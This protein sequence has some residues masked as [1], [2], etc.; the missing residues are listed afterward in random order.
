MAQRRMF[1]IK[2]I[3]S[4]KFLKMPSSTRLL[5]YDL[6]MRADDDG[7]VEAF[8]VLRMTG[9]TEDDLRVLAS[10]GYIKVLNEDLVTYIFDW[11]EHNKI[12]ADRKIDSLYKD[13]LLQI[14][15]EVKLVER[16]QRAD[17]KAKLSNESG[18]SQRQPKDCLGQDRLGQDRLGQDRTTIVEIEEVLKDF[19]T[20][21]L[22]SISKFCSKNNISVDVVVEK[23]NIIK[24]LKK[25]DNRVGALITAIKEDWKPNK[26]QVNNNCNF[27]Q[28]DYDYDSLE[29]QL[30]GWE[31]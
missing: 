21:E 28:R 17:R 30:L 22:E 9:A 6:G 13:L 20:E 1:S 12:R 4:A 3:D 11:Q 5:Y 25:I 27:S 2:I 10:K 8:N 14:I 29:K 15:P 19:N 26:G 7:I 16:K 18:T 24:N 31:E 23:F